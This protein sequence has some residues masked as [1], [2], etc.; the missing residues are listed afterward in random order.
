MTDA[1]RGL[2]SG[3]ISILVMVMVI[4]LAVLAVL[5]MATAQ[6]AVTYAERQ[7]AITRATYDNEAAA[8]TLVSQIDAILERGRGARSVERA[9]LVEALTHFVA[10]SDVVSAYDLTAL[11]SDA[12]GVVPEADVATPGDVAVVNGTF[13][14]EAGRELQ[15]TLVIGEDLS[16]EVSRWKATTVWDEDAQAEQLWQGPAS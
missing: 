10:T 13:T 12:A 14:Q 8:N 15:V 7:A 3:P 2:R 5:S 4:C 16:L 11:G 1:R 9:R 6:A